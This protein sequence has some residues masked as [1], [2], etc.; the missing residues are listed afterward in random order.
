M[1]FLTIV[2]LAFAA[3]VTAR[4]DYLPL[5]GAGPDV[6][7]RR[8]IGFTNMARAVIAQKAAPAVAESQ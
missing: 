6:P 7:Q 1:Q 4:N 5:R 3:T 2:V 8:S